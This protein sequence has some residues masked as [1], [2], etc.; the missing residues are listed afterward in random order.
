MSSQE[1]ESK[2]SYH[3]I[4]QISMVDDGVFTS[5]RNKNSKCRCECHKKLYNG[6]ENSMYPSTPEERKNL[7]DITG[8][9]EFTFYFA[10]KLSMKLMG[11]SDFQM[12]NTPMIEDFDCALFLMKAMNVDNLK[13][14]IDM[15]EL[16]IEDAKKKAKEEDILYDKLDIEKVVPFMELL[17]NLNNKS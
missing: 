5:I 8:N 4:E 16:S 17:R 15:M 10:F 13:T 1:S 7:Y 3:P 11:M 6:I 14:W 9:G 12:K 2:T